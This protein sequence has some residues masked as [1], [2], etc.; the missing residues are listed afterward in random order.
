VFDDL[1]TLTLYVKFRLGDV[2]Y[3]KISADPF[4]GMVTGINIR[5]GGQHFTITWEDGRDSDHYEMELTT[6][7]I[8]EFDEPTGDANVFD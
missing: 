3:L 5:P 2:V 4:K 6:E 7:Y 8:E 1:K